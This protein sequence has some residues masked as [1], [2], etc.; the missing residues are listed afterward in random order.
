[1]SSSSGLSPCTAGTSPPPGSGSATARTPSA[2]APRVAGDPPVRTTRRIPATPGEP[3]KGRNDGLA[4]SAQPTTE[5]ATWPWW[6]LG[7][8]ILGVAVAIPVVIVRRRRNGW[9]ERLALAE[10]EIVWFARQLLPQLQQQQSVDQVAGAW[11]VTRDR[12]SALEDTL[13]GLQSTARRGPEEALARNLRDSVRAAR[14]Q[15]DDVAAAP[16]PMAPPADITTTRTR[17]VQRY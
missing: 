6:L 3:G 15:L 2:A 9:R 14:I 11:Q 5:P 17:S 13:T 4:A 1:M 8:I 10:S 16:G 12:V 7:A